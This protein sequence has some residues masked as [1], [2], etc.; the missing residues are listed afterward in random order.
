MKS[1]VRESIK[2]GNGKTLITHYTTS[3][4][5]WMSVLKFVFFL[6]VL[7]PIEIGFLLLKYF[8]I[9]LISMKFNAFLHKK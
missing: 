7:W 4:Y 5:F 2:L 6:L 9:F 1:Y 8:C 3:E